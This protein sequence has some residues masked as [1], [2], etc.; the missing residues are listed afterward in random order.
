MK[1]RR[2]GPRNGFSFLEMLTALAILV[3]ICGV[4]FEL[5]FVSMKKYRSDSQLLN[6]FQEARFGLDQIVRDINDA[7]Y[8]PRN[9][10]Q[11]GAT[12]QPQTYAASAFAWSNGGATYPNSPCSIGT[13]CT[14]T[15]N[16]WDLIVETDIDPQNKNSL[17]QV[18]WIRYQLQGTTLFR[19]V[20][21]KDDNSP[22]DPDS[23]TSGANLV[24]YIQN[25]MNNAPPAQIAA[26]QAAY[27]SMFPGGNPVPLFQ[28]YCETTPQPVK[29]DG[30]GTSLPSYSDPKHVVS[31]VVT[32]IVQAP[33]ADMQTG[34]PLVVQLQGIGRRLNPDY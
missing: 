13:T 7:G 22:T 26:L 14:I 23:F 17:N 10:F 11:G 29:C 30:T 34:R 24:P 5:L 8:P 21:A 32:L 18:E 16:A 33:T 27:P 3:L 2:H 4:A 1:S 9:N 31:V 15:P 25:V 20:V 6:S 12:P 28:Y 19:G